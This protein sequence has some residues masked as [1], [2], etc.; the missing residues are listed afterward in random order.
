VP[1]FPDRRSKAL[2]IVLGCVIA[3][4]CF[5]T[6]Y[7]VGDLSR[8]QRAEI[9]QESEAALRHLDAPEQLDPLL[10]RYPSSRILKL[11]ALA[12]RD[13]VEIDDTARGLL[14]EADPGDLWTRMGKAVSSRGDLEALGRDLKAAQDNAASL[15][16]RY[17]ALG[18]AVR[19]K[20]EHDAN[21]LEGKTSTFTK[22]MAVVDA[23]HAGMKDVI[24]KTS[25]ARLDYFRAYEK[26]V[27]LLA[28]EFEATKVVNGQFIFRIQS[29]ADSYNKAAATMASS[30]KRLA[31][32]DSERAA[33]RSSQFEQWKRLGGD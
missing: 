29:Q 12:R 30:A 25:A 21:A 3:I 19:D 6:L 11:V 24:A 5:G 7:S 2:A 4:V 18:K 33:L 27:G 20:V 31:E 8:F 28:S 23:Q 22:L 26:C 17:A 32:L 16:S 1:M 13:Q 14:R 15:E 10:K 9:A